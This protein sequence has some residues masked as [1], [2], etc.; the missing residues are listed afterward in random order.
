VGRSTDQSGGQVE[1][2]GSGDGVNNDFVGE[3]DTG[4]QGQKASKYD[5]CLQLLWNDMF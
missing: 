5:K 3:G 1:G 2:R 4:G